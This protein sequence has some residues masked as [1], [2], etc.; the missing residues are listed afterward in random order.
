MAQ[1]IM[2]ILVCLQ[3][4][5]KIS[6]SHDVASKIDKPLGVYIFTHT[7]FLGFLWTSLFDD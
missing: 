7:V 5:V 1:E 6:L 2:E 3:S 4:C